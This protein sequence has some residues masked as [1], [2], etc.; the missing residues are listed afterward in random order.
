[1]SNGLLAFG[2]RVAGVEI[3]GVDPATEPRLNRVVRSIGAGR[4]LR[5][6]D[7]GATV[8][9]QGVADRLRVRLDDELLVTVAARDG[10]LQSA[11]L[12]I[13][14]I[15]RTGS[16]TVDSTVCQIRLPELEALTGRPGAAEVAVLLERSEEMPAVQAA[17][18]KAL[19]A[20]N[21]V[22]TW[23]EVLPELKASFDLD[24]GFTRLLIGTI[25]LVVLLGITSAQLASVL[26]RR[27]EFAVLSAL[28]MKELS[29][30]RLLLLEAGALG[31]LGAVTGLLL[32]VPV[33]YYLATVGID[34]GA[35]VDAD[36]AIS[37]VLIDKVFHADMGF[38]LVP[39]ALAIALGATLVATVYPA[40]FAAKT[41]P[42]S[43][44]RVA[45]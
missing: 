42:A 32:G 34:Y 8:I 29:I 11:I 38:W 25:I 15:V 31:L 21:V 19:P 5:P 24:Q 4:Y 13:V 39:Q 40:W 7:R 44:L 41:D 20:G 17:L 12:R 27:R 16:Q 45:Q 37:N 23:I 18:Q 28:G 43:A 1:R 9:G 2:T 33:V 14:G 3:V 22:H 35:F 10:N 6:D 30:A 26:E 36:L